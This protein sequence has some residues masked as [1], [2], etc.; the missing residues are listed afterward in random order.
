MCIPFH[1]AMFVPTYVYTDIAH[2]Y[3]LS[4]SRVDKNTVAHPA[5]LAGLTIRPY[6]LYILYC[7][8]YS[9]LREENN[10]TPDHSNE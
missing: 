2:T 8:E 1:H 3:I 6:I 4:R 7:I 9:L 5:L 10:F